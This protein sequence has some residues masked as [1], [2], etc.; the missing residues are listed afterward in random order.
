MENALAAGAKVKAFDSVAAANLNAQMPEVETVN[1]MYEAL[2][3]ADALIIATEW[4]EFRNPDF[5]KMAERMNQPVI[6]DGRN[7]Y[8][9][10]RSWRRAASR[11][12]R[13]AD[14]RWSPPYAAMRADRECDHGPGSPFAFIHLAW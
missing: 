9:R 3:D 14:R 4:S 13:W 11:T 10:S 7:I 2:D 12:S 6:F 1:D 8:R 5:E